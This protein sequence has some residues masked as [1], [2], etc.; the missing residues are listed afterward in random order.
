MRVVIIADERFA[1]REHSLIARLQVGL[2]D[3]GV[4]VVQA[5]P[6]GGASHEA[7]MFTEVVTY[8]DAGLPLSLRW[9]AA[10]TAG[11]LTTP[12]KGGEV[13]QPQAVH[14]FGGKVWGFAVALAEK[15][16]AALIL[17]T[18]RAGLS[19]GLQHAVAQAKG[20]PGLLALCPDKGL[21]DLVRA[22]APG[23][24]VQYSPWGVYTREPAT[25]AL[26]PGKAWSIMIAGAGLDREAF[27]AAFEAIADVL[28]SR[29]DALVFADAVAARRTDLWR[30]AARLGVRERLSLVDEMD[31]NRD[32][33]LRGDVLVL[34][35]AR[36][37]QR[38]LVLEAMGGGMP[39]VAA[40]DPANTT[41]ID[42][43]SAL[44]VSGGTRTGWGRQLE[45][46]LG[47][48]D[49]QAQLTAS[50]RAYIAEE[51]RPSRQV[52]CVI[53]AY[54]TAIGKAPIPFPG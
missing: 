38:T 37:E 6:E 53:D 26:Q 1:S 3:Q 42:R 46:L 43:R 16:E 30:L 24:G 45:A 4:R 28:R 34:P 41:L 31:A 18:W 32:L 10:T 19:R 7:G 8:E 11:K 9:R 12:P 54:E 40:A 15:L 48:G 25:P 21:A 22:Q 20:R 33:V 27:G 23:L 36:G 44:L 17:E 2:A 49:L 47:D 35:E 14:A 51:H 5:L 50:A 39:V 29:P 13:E 52:N